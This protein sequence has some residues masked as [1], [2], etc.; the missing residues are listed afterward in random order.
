MIFHML[1]WIAKGDGVIFHILTWI[2]K[3]FVS[4]KGDYYESFENPFNW[5]SSLGA[6]V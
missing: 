2:A 6:T 4:P 3:G 1:T 5:Y